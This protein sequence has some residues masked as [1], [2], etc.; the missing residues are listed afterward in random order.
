[1]MPKEGESS[2]STSSKNQNPLKRGD[3]CLYCRKRRIRCSADKPT[4]QH[5]K[6]KRECVYDSGKPVSRVKQ[7]EEKV[8]ELEGLLKGES[9]NGNH[10]TGSGNGSRRA[11]EGGGIP[12]GG[13]G[14]GTAQ[15]PLH[16]Q[17]NDQSTTSTSNGFAD[18]LPQASAMNGF[19]NP[20]T[21]GADRMDGIQGFD[22]NTLQQA[23]GDITGVNGIANDFFAFGSSMFGP[24]GSDDQYNKIPNVVA[25]S[26]PSDPS[27]MFDFSTLD[28]NFMSLVNSFDNTF[29]APA[30]V[31]QAVPQQQPAAAS[32]QPAYPPQPMGSGSNQST[33]SSTG[34]TPFLN[35]DF[36]P[37]GSGPSPPISSG[38]ISAADP[39]PTPTP[40]NHFENLS[41]TV[42]YSAHGG[43]ASAGSQVTQSSRPQTQA[44]ALPPYGWASLKHDV[45]PGQ[46]GNDILLSQALGEKST[47]SSAPSNGQGS[48]TYSSGYQMPTDTRAGQGADLGQDGFELVGGWFDANDLPRVARDHL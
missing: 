14:N 22:I 1:M 43:A 40:G 5:C 8:A 30:P 7:L 46:T 26:L 28:P 41:K 37:S 29:Q 3:A 2:T 24:T 17:S 11:S 12:G 6:G 27:A 48:T 18:T 44:S 32:R 20:G 9:G 21:A 36:S 34:L 45:G 23:Y 35:Q 4:C 19:V 13:A 39:G 25:D 47:E 42:N 16:H 38:Y 15:P 10:G 33:E 31:P